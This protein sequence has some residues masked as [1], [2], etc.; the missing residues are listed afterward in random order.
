MTAILEFKTRLILAVVSSFLIGFNHVHAQDDLFRWILSRGYANDEKARSETFLNRYYPPFPGLRNRGETY[1]ETNF[2]YDHLVTGKYN[3][4]KIRV[5]NQNYSAEYRRPLRFG[6]TD[7][8]QIVIRGLLAESTS[9]LEGGI[10]DQMEY[11]ND[12]GKLTLTYAN[13]LWEVLEIGISGGWASAM[14][15]NFADY[16]AQVSL[17]YFNSRLGFAF[18]RNHFND[19]SKFIYYDDT[20]FMPMSYAQKNY[21]YFLESDYIRRLNIRFYADLDR[22]QPVASYKEMYSSIPVARNNAYISTVS[23]TTDQFTLSTYACWRTA[24]DVSRL[25][26]SDLQY[27]KIN[28]PNLHYHQ[29]DMVVSRRITNRLSMFTGYE[30]Q[31]MKSHVGLNVDSWP[32]TATVGSLFG[33]TYYGDID[34]KAG[35]QSIQIGGSMQMNSR[36]S[37]GARVKF[38]NLKIDGTYRDRRL[39][40]FFQVIDFTNDSNRIAFNFLSAGI[41]YQYHYSRINVVVLFNKLIPVSR[42]SDRGRRSLEKFKITDGGNFFQIQMKYFL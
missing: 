8:G 7:S 12:R 39:D 33:A 22:I 25:E 42:S 15:K 3:D 9:K 6:N 28:I 37:F 4:T 19:Y 5:A 1:V 11:F 31:F 35:V 30:R 36:Q 27:G 10:D 23:L 21:V 34:G 16:G 20:I 18:S 40:S 26:K 13:K 17:H 32:F 29:Y 2:Q 41:V 14:N 24:E 38:M